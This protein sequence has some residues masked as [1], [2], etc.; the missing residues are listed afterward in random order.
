MLKLNEIDNDAFFYSV[1]KLR[2]QYS[3]KKKT[4][5][6][7]CKN[8]LFDV[9]YT[10]KN[11]KGKPTFHVLKNEKLGDKYRAGYRTVIVSGMWRWCT[12]F[13]G[14]YGSSRFH[15]I[16]THV[17]ACLLYMYYYEYLKKEMPIEKLEELEWIEEEE[18]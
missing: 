2:G 12:C 1:N 16:C 5:F 15:K 3:N 18:I 10:G 14:S 8:R 6:D 7:T 9:V 4:W 11:K 17:G 13:F